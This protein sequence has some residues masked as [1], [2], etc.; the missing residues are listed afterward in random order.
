MEKNLMNMK[1]VQ[2]LSVKFGIQDGVIKVSILI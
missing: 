2:E 1:K